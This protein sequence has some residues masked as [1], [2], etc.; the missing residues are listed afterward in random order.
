MQDL[1]EPG[2]AH[3]GPALELQ[4]IHVPH[5][6]HEFH[7]ANLELDVERGGCFADRPAAVLGARVMGAGILYGAGSSAAAGSGAGRHESQR[8][9]VDFHRQEVLA[10]L[11]VLLVVRTGAGEQACVDLVEVLPLRTTALRSSPS[12][13][14]VTAPRWASSR[15]CR[16]RSMRTLT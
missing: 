11:Q 9:Q 15:P 1:L 13:G 12:S 2:Q 7:V 3:G 8:S 6:Q 16:M 10:G 4:V 5:G 14:R